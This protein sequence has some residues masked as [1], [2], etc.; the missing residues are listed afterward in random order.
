MKHCLSAKYTREMTVVRALC[1]ENLKLPLSGTQEVKKFSN[2][3]QKTYKVAYILHLA[4]PLQLCSLSLINSTVKVTS[5]VNPLWT[6]IFASLFHLAETSRKKWRGK[7]TKKPILSGFLQVHFAGYCFVS[8]IKYHYWIK[9]NVSGVLLDC[10]FFFV[11]VCFLLQ[12]LHIL[13][14]T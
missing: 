1:K 6:W 4:Q 3:N 5:S 11:C 12:I 14:T 2:S 8:C 7:R 9:K 10:C 13:S